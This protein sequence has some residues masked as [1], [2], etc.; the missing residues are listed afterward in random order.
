M[1]IVLLLLLRYY[2]TNKLL[3][4]VFKLRLRTYT[5]FILDLQLQTA[6]FTAD[7]CHVVDHV[8]SRYPKASIYAVGWSLG[9]NILVN[10]LG[11]VSEIRFFF[12]KVRTYIGHKMKSLNNITRLM[13][14]FLNFW[15]AGAP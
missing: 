3:S 8:S 11:R 10:Y 14:K 5:H 7:T 1:Q 12:F 4:Y 13:Y 6:S 15:H 9:G 2:T